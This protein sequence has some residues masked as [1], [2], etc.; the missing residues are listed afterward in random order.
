MDTSVAYAPTAD[1]NLSLNGPGWE[2][3]PTEGVILEVKFTDRAPRWV[4]GMIRT[5]GLERCS[6]PKYVLSLDRAFDLH[7]STPWAGRP[8][9]PR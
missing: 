5:L 2:D 9:T 6:I 1:P 8:R 3:T 7:G 4:T